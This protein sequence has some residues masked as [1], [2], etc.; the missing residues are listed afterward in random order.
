[1]ITSTRNEKVAAALRLKKRA[2]R[3]RERRFLVEGAQAVGEAL[4]QP[5]GLTRLYHT[6]GAHPL[7]EDARSAG[8]ELVHVSDE[9]MG[10]L[11][12]TVTPQGL[13][14]ISPLVDVGLGSVTYS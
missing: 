12:S 13:V 9:V 3:E 5:D 10:K 7:V 4:T 8:A 1:V 14:G 6:D 11:T 2:L